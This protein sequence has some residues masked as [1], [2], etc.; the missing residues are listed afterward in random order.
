[1]SDELIIAL[2]SGAVT[3]IATILTVWAGMRK[4]AQNNAVTLAITT[5]KLEELTKEVRK[6]NDFANRIP[7]LEEKMKVANHRLDDLEEELK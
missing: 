1:M 3:I 5:T 6:H 7:V 2:I 4:S